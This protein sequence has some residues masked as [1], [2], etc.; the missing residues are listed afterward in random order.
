[1][2]IFKN[3]LPHNLY[4]TY[5]IESDS[6]ITVPS[7]LEY[8]ESTGSMNK[9][10][11]DMLCQ[12]YDAFSVEDSLKI[13]EWHLERGIEDKKRIC[14]I[15]TKFINNDAERTLLKILEEP[16]SNTH[17][18]IIVPN[19]S[20]LLDTIKSRAHVI[21]L[22]N[23]TSG[24]NNAEKFIKSSIAERLKTIEQIIAEHKDSD[25]SG[26][27]RHEAISLI[28]GIEK[29]IYQKWKSDKEPNFNFILDELSKSRECLSIPGASVKMVLENI[30]LVI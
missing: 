9:N 30:A 22:S 26:G 29:T 8:L 18:F 21:R 5:I 6:D 17:F 27:L 4:H 1:M 16:A 3:L 15:N 12:N 13:K 25:N 10:S 14:I 28:N 2:N 19:A 20:V 23:E 7:L 11:A 24:N